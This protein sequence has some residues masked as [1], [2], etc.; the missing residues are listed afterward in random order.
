MINYLCCLN[1]YDTKFRNDK[2]SCFIESGGE[3]SKNGHSEI[4]KTC[5]HEIQNG[6]DEP[7]VS[8]NYL[9]STTHREMKILLLCCG[10]LAKHH[11]YEF[12]ISE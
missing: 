10:L 11:K 6:D 2:L 1:P 3:K 12:S 8:L 5:C 7:V 4:Q 9:C